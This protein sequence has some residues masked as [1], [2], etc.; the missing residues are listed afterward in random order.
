MNAQDESISEFMGRALRDP[1]LLARLIEE[2]EQ[3]I[4]TQAVPAATGSRRAR[5]IHEAA[6]LALV[7]LQEWQGGERFGS[8][9]TSNEETGGIWS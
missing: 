2:L 4:G 9:S 5:A 6:G 8:T 7:T 1:E 3:L